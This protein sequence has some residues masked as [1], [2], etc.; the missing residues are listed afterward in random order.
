MSACRS[1]IILTSVPITIIALIAGVALFA[2][3]NYQS[4]QTPEIG[5]LPIISP[6][7]VQFIGILLVILMAAHLITLLTDVPFAGR[8]G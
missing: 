4:R 3:G 6:I 2:Y 1:S 8:R 7:A 5:K